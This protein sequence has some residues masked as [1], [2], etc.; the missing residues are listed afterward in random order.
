MFEAERELEAEL[1]DLMAVLSESDVEAEAESATPTTIAFKIPEAPYSDEA[2]KWIHG[3]IDLFEAIHTTI[4]IFGPSL[5]ELLGAVGLGIEVLG[6]L[7]GFVGSMFVLGAGYAESRAVISRRRIQT[8]FALGVVTG[9]D[10]R[11]WPYVKR[12]FWE[13]AP[14]TNTFDQDAGKIAQKAFN[15]GLATGFLQGKEIA[16]NPRKM[17]FFWDSIRVTLS[18]GDLMQ[19]AGDSKLWPERLWRDWYLRAM[20]GFIGRYLKK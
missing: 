9:A 6:P 17:K 3:S 18:Q 2:F 12:L 15:M 5:L 19:F 16:R 20:A 14:E 1:E 8:G 13:F 7:A 10:K 11:P 4:S